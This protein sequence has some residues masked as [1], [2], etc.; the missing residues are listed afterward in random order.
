MPGSIAKVSRVNYNK[1]SCIKVFNRG[2]IV[3]IKSV[4]T[5]T[6]L[7]FSECSSTNGWVLLILANMKTN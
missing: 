3:N 2:P 6:T 5:C 1:A 4:L 7:G